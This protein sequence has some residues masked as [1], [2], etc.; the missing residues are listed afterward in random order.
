VRAEDQHTALFAPCFAQHLQTVHLDLKTFEA[1][2]EKKCPVER[3]GSEAV[4]VLR[5]FQQ[6]G[7]LA[8]NAP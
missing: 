3:H 2:G 4:N 6:R 8:G 1:L 5:H 7:A